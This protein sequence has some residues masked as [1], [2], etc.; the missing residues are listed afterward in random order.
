MVYKPQTDSLSEEEYAIL[1]QLNGLVATGEEMLESLQRASDRRIADSTR[2]FTSHYELATHIISH[3]RIS[4]EKPISE[5]G[6]G[7]VDLLFDFLAELGLGTPKYI[8]RYLEGLDGNLE[9]RPL[10]Q[11][12][13]DALMAEDPS[14]YGVYQNVRKR[15]FALHD[16]PASFDALVGRFLTSWISLEQLERDLVP[17]VVTGRR[18]SPTGRLLST[19]GYIDEDTARRV[20][21]LRRLRNELVHGVEQPSSAVLDEAADQIDAIVAAINSEF[22]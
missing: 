9:V 19:A 22:P 11:Q 20:D 21:Y 3:P 16:E 2:K 6:L 12:V 10:A 5:S 4:T 18:I 1:D 7:R 13:I 14:R 15:R 17:P 8:D